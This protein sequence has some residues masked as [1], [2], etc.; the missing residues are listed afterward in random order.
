V[1]YEAL[2]LAARGRALAARGRTKAALVPLRRAVAL[3]RPVGDPAMFLRAATAQLEVDGDDE[4]AGEARAAA[5][6][7]LDALP[8]AALRCAF[9][10][11]EPVRRLLRTAAT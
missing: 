1:K 10:A 5:G 3:V 2:G 7:I 4:L 9:A 11:A 8:D 6:R